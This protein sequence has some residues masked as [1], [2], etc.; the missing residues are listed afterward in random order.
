M[1]VPT[2]CTP[3]P[4]ACPANFYCDAITSK[5]VFGCQTN[6]QCTNG[7]IRRHPAEHLRVPDGIEPVWW[8]VRAGEHADGVR[9]AV[10]LVRRWP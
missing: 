1:N 9:L 7:Q 3:G 8:L 2:T 5:C 10:P 6:A 4:N